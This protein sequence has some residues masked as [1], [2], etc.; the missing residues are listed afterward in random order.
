MTTEN[1]TWT[2]YSDWGCVLLIMNCEQ[3][4]YKAN[5][6]KDTWLKNIKIPYYHVIGDPS[7][8]DDYMFHD[9]K[10]I[11]W[12]KTKDDYNSLP[13]K[14]IAS[15]EAVYNRFYDLKYVFKTDD[16][17]IL[18]VDDNNSFFEK[19]VNMLDR[20]KVENYKIHYSGNIVNVN[21]AY[22]S[23][24]HRIHPEL[25]IDLPIL[26]TKYCSGR[27]YM[28]SEEAIEDLL[29]KKHYIEKEFLEDYA[30]GYYLD[31][32]FKINMKHFAS[33]IFFKDME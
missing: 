24:Y 8:D 20:N 32:K 4:F 5:K 29:K 22:I 10:K 18:Q 33:N 14:V 19:I 28:L 27:F 17:Q 31:E 6:Q 26:P 2:D 9:K 11:L 25:P 21:Q 30:I 12:V 3:Y 15:Y 1:N 13:K 7:L 16:D 23:Q